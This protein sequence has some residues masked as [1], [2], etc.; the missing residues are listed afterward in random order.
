[1]SIIVRGMEM[2]TDCR[3][4]PMQVYYS[5]GKTW[6]KSTDRVLSEDYKPI[7]YD[8]IPNWCP[9]VELPEKHGRLVDA[10]ELWKKMSKYTDNEGAKFPYVDDDSM[11]HRDSACFMIENADTIIEAEGWEE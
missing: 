2:P 7:P 8:G 1:M 4:C 9:L 3:E 5:S 11:I 10:D 6:C